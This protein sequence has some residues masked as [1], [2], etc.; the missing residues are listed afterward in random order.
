MEALTNLF[1]EERR[2]AIMQML[3]IDSKIIVSDLANKFH[4]SSATIRNDLK[5]L[6]SQGLLTRTHGGAIMNSG[7]KFE[8]TSSAKIRTMMN[9]KK[10]LAQYAASMISDGETIVLD[11]G[12]TM[13]YLSESLA[14]K[15]NLTIVTNDIEIASHL[16]KHTSSNILLAGGSL[17]KGFHCTLGQM[18][19]DNL[20][21]LNVDKAFIATNGINT[22][23]GLTTPDMN[24]AAVKKAMMDMADEVIVVTTSNKLSHSAFVSFA[25][26]SEIDH[27][28]ID[29]PKSQSNILQEIAN[30]GVKVH[31]VPAS[32]N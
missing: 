31:I 26:I 3:K 21:G 13:L 1:A 2:T 11:T 6:E 24:Q 23:N 29:E 5:E 19:L 22:G 16:E 8:L 15:K 4:T 10:M 32:G 9:E 25:S 12:S 20:S 28:V 14:D 7:V 18:T 27:L 17:R 30:L